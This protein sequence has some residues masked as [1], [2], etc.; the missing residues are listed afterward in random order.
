MVDHVSFSSPWQIQ[1]AKAH[2]SEVIEK[3]RMEGPQVIARH[4]VERAVVLSIEEYRTLLA[5][6]PDF[7]AHLLG[8]PKVDDFS[9]E[10]DQG[11]GREV[12][13]WA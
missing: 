3:A 1:K 13:L 12:E 5:H 8:G 6:Q 9:V 10:R 7:T 11:M 4:G 2:F